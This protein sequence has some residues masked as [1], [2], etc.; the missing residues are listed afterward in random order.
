V[1]I[2]AMGAIE[3]VFERAPVDIAAEAPIA[4]LRLTVTA[5]RWSADEE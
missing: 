4:T 1:V 2:P 5:Q 3:V